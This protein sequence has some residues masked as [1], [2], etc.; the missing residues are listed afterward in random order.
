MASAPVRCL[1]GA[2]IGMGLEWA[3]N[4]LERS[5]MGL[6]RVW[7]GSG[8]GL[9]RVWN[10]SGNAVCASNKDVMTLSDK[11]CE[12]AL[13]GVVATTAAINATIGQKTIDCALNDLRL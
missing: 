6:E 1:G 9:E 10:G 5:G 4:G 12:Y 11:C 13:H 2:C 7:N 8:M 3:W